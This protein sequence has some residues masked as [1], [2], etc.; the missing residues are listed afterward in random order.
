MFV[1]RKPILLCVFAG[2]LSAFAP[3]SVDA[4]QEVAVTDTTVTNRAD[5][6]CEN[7]G[8]PDCLGCGAAPGCE[9]EFCRYGN[10][11]RLWCSAEFLQ[12]WIK[13]GQVPPLAT[14]GTVNSLGAL[15]PGTTTL[16][17][18]D[19]NYGERL[20]GRFTIGYWLDSCQTR[21]IEASY[22]FLGGPSDNFSASSSDLPG[23]LLLARPFFN[24]NSLLQDSQQVS[25]P[26]I[27]NGSIGISSNSQLQGAEF[28][29]VCNR[30]CC[31]NDCCQTDSCQTDSC[32]TDCCY[33]S[34]HRVDLI[35]GF[36]YLGL[37]E[38]L[39]IAENLTFLPTAPSPFVPGE[40]ITVVDGFGTRNNFYGG[41][42]GARGEWCRGRWFMNVLGKVALGDTHQEVRISGTTDFTDPGVPTVR[43]QGG[44]LALPTNIGSYSRDQFSVVP[45]IGINVGRQL[46]DHLRVF[47]GYTLL[48]WSSV[49]RPG[50]QI[51][52]IVNPTQ[53][54]TSTGPG[55]L[56]GEARPAFAFH[57]T[58][59]WAQGINLGLELRW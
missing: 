14:V 58:D 27:I 23:S 29:L 15:G 36:R 4:A 12:W 18:G 44:L 46:T 5:V 42:I 28:N 50:D 25:F 31:C 41:Q 52:F 51:D 17:G 20:G 33:Q 49:V 1:W 55:T 56:V 7:C 48:Y 40:T 6:V 38:D 32:Q 39:H 22:F 37:N 13:Q 24:V 35:A 19:L 54:P 57:N 10:G 59:F 9:G 43:Q 21:G 3:S 45:E 11:N 34:G 53:L 47:A 26:D 30:C 8:S 16:F 2:L